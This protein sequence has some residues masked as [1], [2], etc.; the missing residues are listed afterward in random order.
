MEN[1]EE[2]EKEKDELKH[3][4]DD[5]GP[6]KNGASSNIEHIQ[7]E[8]AELRK[9]YAELEEKYLELKFK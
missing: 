4:L 8:F 9:Q 6:G 5:A 7:T 2:L 1:I 3:S